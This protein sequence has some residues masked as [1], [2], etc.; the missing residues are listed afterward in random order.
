[1]SIPETFR[2]PPPCWVLL[3][4]L[5]LMGVIGWLD[6]ITGWEWSFF[7][8]YAVPIVVVVWRMG[9]GVGFGFAALCATT[10]WLANIEENPYHTRWGFALAV[11]GRWFYFSVLVVAVAT[12]KA[13]RGIDRA[14]IEALERAR[15]LEL[16]ILGISKREQERMGR[17]LHDS[18]GPNLAALRYAASFLA[19]DLRPRDP[20]AAAKAEQIGELAGHAVRLARDLARGIVPALSDAASLSLA[21]RELARTTSSLAR[22]AV[23]F[24]ETGGT[25]SLAPEECLHVYRIV[26]EA[27][28][29]ATKH[30]AATKV[31]IA[32]SRNEEAL[33]VTVADDGKGMAPPLNG[34]RGMGLD[35]MRFRAQAL[36]GELKIDS[37]PGEGT[38][39]SCDI[40]N[41][42]PHP[43][44]P[45]R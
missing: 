22:M 15:R 32:L 36:R 11:F 3:G 16:E 14:R 26:Q 37:Q 34:P 17:E 43:A 27:L 19:S 25:Q 31:T 38:I 42:L 21:L 41:R 39:V 45:A 9:R 2:R 5:V 4:A 40:P 35:S 20:A 23:T 18:L 44:L 28:T 10:F 24:H 33:R 12:L 30:G 7:G 29:N 8:P 6:Y 13:K 1:M